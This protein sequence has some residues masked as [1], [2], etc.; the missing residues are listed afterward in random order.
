MEQRES[1][2]ASEEE[3][4]PALS[5]SA[6]MGLAKDAL[7]SVV[8]RLVGEV[9]EVNDKPGYKAVYFTV[10][11][12]KASLPCMMWMNRYQ[13][14]G[15][16][17]YV[18]ALV[19]LTGRFSLY[20][21]KGRMNFD[22]FSVSLAGEGQLRLQVA[23]LARELEAMGLMDPARKR[24]LPAYPSTIGL[25]TSP[26]GDAVHDV[27]RTLRRR[28]PLARVLLAGV[29]VEGPKA[30]DGMVDALAK[31]VFSGAEVVLLVRGGGSFEDLMPFNDRRLARTIAACPVPVVTGIGHE[32]DTSIADM[33]ADVRASTPTAAAEAVA[34]S[35]EQ[36]NALLA[37]LGDR[38]TGAV[39]RR[40]R[41]AALT[42]E[43][44]AGKPLFQEPERLF[45][46][47]ALAL[48]DLSGRLGRA[49]PESLRENRHR[50]ALLRETLR[51]SLPNLL[52][53]PRASVHAAKGRLVFAGAHFGEAEKRTLEGARERLVRLGEGV[54][55]PR[56]AEVAVSA[57]RLHDLSPLAVIGR[58]YAIARTDGGEV[59]RSVAQAPAGSTVS[60]TV[61]DGELA[62]T[63]NEA[64]RIESSV[65]PW[66]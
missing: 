25:V 31:V 57:A 47:E 41:D 52:A 17:L 24:P 26:R 13:A 43:R 12:E 20:A 34:P 8:V 63:V 19:E 59:I 35:R 53:I 30:A 48:D 36:T 10:K 42:V 61:A 49:L 11:D 22:V 32:P 66:N 62:C 45:D 46:A 64:V 7:E 51:R 65:E 37:S 21:A 18:G 27:L 4:A 56:R 23:N 29:P 55:Q 2:E 50:I 33:V 9:S 5:V 44:L 60:V 6:A 1:P 38:A 39:E 3:K 14:S 15:V 54:I 28:Y 16:Q 40:L 58:G